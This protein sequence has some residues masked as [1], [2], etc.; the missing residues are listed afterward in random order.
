MSALLL[1]LLTL[2]F[3][4]VGLYYSPAVPVMKCGTQ[5]CLDQYFSEWNAFYSQSTIRAYCY[6]ASIVFGL[7]LVAFSYLARLRWWRVPTVAFPVLMA[8]VIGFTLRDYSAWVA[9]ESTFAT[10]AEAAVVFIGLFLAWRYLRL[11][12]EVGTFSPA[13]P[14]WVRLNAL[15][16]GLAGFAVWAVGAGL[17]LWIYIPRAIGGILPSAGP[18]GF[19]ATPVRVHGYLPAIGL[20][21]AVAAFIFSELD[22]KPLVRSLERGL[23]PVAAG[24][25]V[26]FVLLLATDIGET[27][28][29]VFSELAG[30]RVGSLFLLNNAVGV[31]VSSLLL[32]KLRWKYP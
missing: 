16:A 9:P 27:N 19:I 26:F 15:A 21:V 18:S 12:K 30:F 25:F 20:G 22:G 24:A 23:L 7:A 31:A 2:T 29:Q 11:P 32:L 4:V 13:L 1:A 10:V 14:R 3:S 5:A 28:L 8:L 6:A 17:E